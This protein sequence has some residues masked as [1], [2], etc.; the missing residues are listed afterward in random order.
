MCGVTLIVQFFFQAHVA[1]KCYHRRAW[2]FVSLK[3]LVD[4]FTIRNVWFNWTHKDLWKRL[5]SIS[6]PRSTSVTL[7][8]VTITVSFEINCSIICQKLHK[9]GYLKKR[10][11]QSS[12]QHIYRRT[13]FFIFPYFHLM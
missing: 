10:K 6:I 4:I 2:P 7:S 8:L 1:L 9:D 12:Q 5:V 11:F 13:L 3:M